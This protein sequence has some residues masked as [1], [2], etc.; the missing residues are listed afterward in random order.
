MTRFTF[1]ILLIFTAAGIFISGV[2]SSWKEISALRV[3]IGGL[4]KVNDELQEIAKIRD[5]LTEQYNAIPPSDI[6]KLSS[7][8]PSGPGTA[9]YLR[10]IELLATKYGIFLKS[11]DFIKQERPTTQI[12]L[13]QQRLFT[14]LGIAFSLKGSYDSL[15]LFLRDLEK[16]IRI[17]DISEISF[18]AQQAAGA[19]G[20]AQ[21]L[22]ALEYALKG[23]IYHAR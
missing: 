16:V 20:Q 17:T 22:Q 23:T 13:P 8:L 3:E 10:D 4:I 12:Q 5:E 1:G 6:A 15:R 14:P 18:S 19:A 7:I 9:Q 2:L 11:I 21:Q